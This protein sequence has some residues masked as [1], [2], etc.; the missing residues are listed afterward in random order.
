[1]PKFA[2]ENSFLLMNIKKKKNGG[3]KKVIKS[4]SRAKFHSE[5]GFLLMELK[6]TK[7][8]KEKVEGNATKWFSEQSLKISLEA[9]FK[10]LDNLL[11]RFH[12]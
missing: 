8:R 7:Q 5:N 2:S 1:M 6:K 9:S 11:G 10:N 4:R 3:K 12:I